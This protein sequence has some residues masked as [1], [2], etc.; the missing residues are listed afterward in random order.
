MVGFFLGWDFRPNNLCKKG[1]MTCKYCDN[2]VPDTRRKN[3]SYCS[4]ECYKKAK[5]ER[6]QKQY[7]RASTL[8]RELRNN[9]KTLER[10]YPLCKMGQYSIPV[11]YFL[12]E[13]F[14]WDRYD[15]LI[16][17]QDEHYYR[18]GQYAY[19]VQVDEKQKNVLICK[20]K[21]FHYN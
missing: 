15:E 13:Q 12:N 21:E 9:E 5:S 8:H 19:R 10:F 2:E 11:D 20:L 7:Y 1:V 17:H 14:V 18:V 4:N 16:S 6:D 3:A